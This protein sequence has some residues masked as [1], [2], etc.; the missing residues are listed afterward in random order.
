M[1]VENLHE[2]AN[3]NHGRNRS[4]LWSGLETLASP[5]FSEKTSVSEI[6]LKKLRAKA[7]SLGWDDVA[8]TTPVIRRRI[9]LLTAKWLSNGYQAQLAYMENDL[10][11]ILSVFPRS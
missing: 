8:C 9:S 5:L 2:V 10:D 3:G 7:L 11:A 1:A 4:S 6:S